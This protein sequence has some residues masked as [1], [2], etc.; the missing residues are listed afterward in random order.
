MIEHQI[1]LFPYRKL[2]YLVLLTVSNENRMFFGVTAPGINREVAMAIEN[3]DRLFE[4]FE[5]TERPE[6]CE[7]PE[8]PLGIPRLAVLHQ[9]HVSDLFRASSTF[10]SP[11]LLK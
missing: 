8:R 9:Y 5:S 3:A 11:I 7:F 10:L 1:F 2:Y 6:N 4:S